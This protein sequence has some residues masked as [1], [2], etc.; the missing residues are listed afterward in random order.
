MPVFTGGSTEGEEGGGAEHQSL[1]AP[2]HDQALGVLLD[3]TEQRC[4]FQLQVACSLFYEDGSVRFGENT[5]LRS[6]FSCHFI[7]RHEG[8]VGW[9]K[10]HGSEGVKGQAADVFLNSTS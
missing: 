8:G 3:D 7:V 9:L 2:V 4:E 10:I 6:A 5:A 1:W